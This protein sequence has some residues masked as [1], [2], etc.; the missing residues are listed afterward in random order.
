MLSDHTLRGETIV[1]QWG[2]HTDMSWTV[3]HQA[4]RGE[5]IITLP[6]FAPFLSIARFYYCGLWLTGLFFKQLF[7]L[8]DQEKVFF[9]KPGSEENLSQ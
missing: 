6:L 5:A 9:Q 1:H 7:L 8:K 2:P 4:L 3:S